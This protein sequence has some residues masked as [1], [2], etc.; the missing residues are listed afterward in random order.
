[1]K[2]NFERVVEAGME[3][4]RVARET[5]AEFGREGEKVLEDA[6]AKMES[7]N[8]LVQNLEDRAFLS[9]DPILVGELNLGTD[10]NVDAAWAHLEVGNY[11]ADLGNFFRAGMKD[12]GQKLSGKYRVL[13]LFQRMD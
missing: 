2:E 11:N 7:L 10:T 8:G 3:R 12:H 5:L 1:M 9:Y 6:K 4:L 13:V